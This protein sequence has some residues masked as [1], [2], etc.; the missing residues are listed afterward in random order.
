[1][2]ETR[3]GQRASEHESEQESEKAKGR[4]GRETT[5]QHDTHK[6]LFAYIQVACSMCLDCVEQKDHARSL[7]Q[8]HTFR[9][10]VLNT[11]ASIRTSTL[12]LLVDVR[13]MDFE[14]T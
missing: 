1:M 14:K 8:K 4:Q 5:K 3:H 13:H 10:F 7:L 2:L 9:V 6:A 11:R 12:F